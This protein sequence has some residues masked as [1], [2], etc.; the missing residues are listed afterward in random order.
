MLKLALRTLPLFAVIVG[1]AMALGAYMNYSG[2]RSAYLDLIASRM[3][4]V[5]DDVAANVESAVSVGIPPAEQTTLP[6][7]LTR[8]VEADPL[9]RSI[10]VVAP[11]GEVLFGSGSEADRTATPDADSFEVGRTVTNDFG[12]PVVDLHVR[13][14]RQAPTEK[15]DAFATA[16]LADAIPAGLLAALAGSLAALLILRRLHGRAARTVNH[17]IVDTIDIAN[18]EVEKL[19]EGVAPERAS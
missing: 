9:I 14:D 18:R 19:G 17:G 1:F 6:A 4:M 16:V 13:Y 8:L 10:S 15:I 12:A 3:H 5:L 11:D 2:V 7:L